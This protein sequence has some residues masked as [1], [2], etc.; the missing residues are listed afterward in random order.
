MARVRFAA[1]MSR[2][3]RKPGFAVAIY[4]HLARTTVRDGELDDAPVL[5]EA[6]YLASLHFDEPEIA[7]S[8][9][10]E[11]TRFGV[12]RGELVHLNATVRA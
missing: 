1:R 3:R 6:A 5:T 4:R 9:Q 8:I 10:S 2:H 12:R 11:R 7:V